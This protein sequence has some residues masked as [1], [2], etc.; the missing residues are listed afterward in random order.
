MKMEKNREKQ[1]RG[2]EGGRR[3]MEEKIRSIAWH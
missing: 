1:S 3:E 2:S